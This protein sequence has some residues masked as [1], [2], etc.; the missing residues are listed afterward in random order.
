MAEEAASL[1]YELVDLT[2]KIVAAYVA[3]NSV[4]ATELGALIRI[5]HTALI[6]ITADSAAGAGSAEEMVKPTAAQIGKSVTPDG[7]ISFLDG[8]SYKTLKRHLTTHG[9][10]PRSYRERFGLPSDYPM[11]SPDYAAK[12]SA[13]AKQIG[14]GRPGTSAESQP[15]ARDRRRKAA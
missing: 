3:N 6:G 8:R 4:P 12:R 7:L 10:D 5:V 2:G 13:L 9:L 15:A 1:P 14:L 11:V